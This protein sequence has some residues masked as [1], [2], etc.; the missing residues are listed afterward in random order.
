MSNGLKTG[1]DLAVMALAYLFVFYPKWKKQKRGYFVVKTIMYFYLCLVF[2]LTLT[3]FIVKLPF[4]F[5]HPYKINIIPYVDY[6][7]EWGD[8][9]RQIIL[10]V[11]MTIPFGILYPMTQKRKKWNFFKTLLMAFLLSLTIE[12]LQL[13][14]ASDRSCDVTDLIDNTVGGLIGY[15]I[16]LIIRHRS[17]KSLNDKK[18]PD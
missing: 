14:V 8:F 18:S 11:L 7:N 1:I 5:S 9:Y 3:P 6:I 13:V 2:Y 12:F 4:I 10:N 15:L 17:R 16:Y